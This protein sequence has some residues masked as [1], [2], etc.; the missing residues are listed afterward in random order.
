MICCAPDQCTLVRDCFSTVR[1]AGLHSNRECTVLPPCIVGA[2]GHYSQSPEPVG[3]AATA[4]PAGSRSDSGR[5]AIEIWLNRGQNSIELRT[6]RWRPKLCRISA[7]IQPL[8]LRPLATAIRPN[9]DRDPAGF[10][11][12]SG[13]IPTAIRSESG[14][15]PGGLLLRLDRGRISTQIRPPPTMPSRGVRLGMHCAFSITM[16]H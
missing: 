2:D 13:R 5:I 14:R 15:G 11:R 1:Y 3:V 6:Q 9:S 8:A 10:R 7:T 16:R 4:L 12:R